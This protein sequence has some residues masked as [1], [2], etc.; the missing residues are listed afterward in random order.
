MLEGPLDVDP[1]HLVDFPHPLRVRHNA[2]SETPSEISHF[3]AYKIRLDSRACKHAFHLNSF[4]FQS[5]KG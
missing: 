5:G 4:F 3:V 2:A 1:R